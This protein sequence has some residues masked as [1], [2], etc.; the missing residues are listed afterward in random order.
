MGGQVLA[1][2]P[3]LARLRWLN[4]HNND[5]GDVGAGELGRSPHA[6]AL[7]TLDLS[8]NS[9]SEQTRNAFPAALARHVH[10]E[11]QP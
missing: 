5:I 10:W 8:D 1:R 9:F 3:G 6:A 4:L 2:W 7:E 11:A